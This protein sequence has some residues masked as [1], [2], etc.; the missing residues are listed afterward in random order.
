MV[1]I[2]ITRLK[3]K[4]VFF[5]FQ[6]MRANEASVKQLVKTSGFLAG[7][8]NMDKHLTFWTLTM[9]KDDACMKDFR[10]SVPHRKAMQKLPYWCNE[11]SYFHWTQEE[12]VL[13]AWPQASERLLLE[14]KITKVRKPTTRQT[15]NKFPSIKWTKFERVFTPLPQL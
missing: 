9:W 2:S 7:K 3:V 1:F 15:A 10:N 6:F 14:G 4:S 13:P 11:A 8:E 12:D 5:L